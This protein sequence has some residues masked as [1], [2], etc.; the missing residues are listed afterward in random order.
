MQSAECQEARE[1]GSLEKLK[2]PHQD[3]IMKMVGISSQ[4]S[5]S[6]QVSDSEAEDP[7]QACQSMK[8]KK[9]SKKSAAKVQKQISKIV[10]KR[11]HL[12]LHPTQAASE[13]D[14]LE[15]ESNWGSNLVM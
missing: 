7:P 10:N 15:K 5:P 1:V 11:K 3:K 13:S 14:D 9:K 12:R 4:P 8:K 6:A 2:K